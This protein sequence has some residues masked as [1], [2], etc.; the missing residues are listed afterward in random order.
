[1][2]QLGPTPVLIMSNDGAATNKDYEP[3][4]SG[5]NGQVKPF[6]FPHVPNPSSF[7]I[8]EFSPQSWMYLVME[9]P[10]LV[11]DFMMFPHEARVMEAMVETTTNATLFPMEGTEENIGAER[12]T[13]AW[14]DVTNFTLKS[15]FIAAIADRTIKAPHIKISYLPDADS[16]RV[17]WRRAMSSEPLPSEALVAGA[18]VFS[19]LNGEGDEVGRLIADGNLRSSV[20]EGARVLLIPA[21]SAMYHPRLVEISARKD[22]GIVVSDFWVPEP[23]QTEMRGS[24]LELRVT[25]DIRERMGVGDLIKAVHAGVLDARARGLVPMIAVDIDGTVLNTRK[26][27]A[28]IFRE[29]LDSYSGPDAEEIK[30]LAH[31][32]RI[33]EAWDSESIL[34]ELGVTRRETVED[35]QKY[36]YSNFHNPVRRLEMPPIQAVVELLRIFQAMG[37]GTIYNTLRNRINDE[38]PDGTSSARMIF[39]RLGIWNERSV[40][41]RD[42]VEDAE[43]FKNECNSC[44]REPLKSEKLRQYRRANPQEF[45]IATIENAPFQING[46]RKFYGDS[47]VNIH[48]AGDIPPDSPPLPEGVFTVKPD[49]LTDD[50]EGWR[51]G[52]STKGNQLADEFFLRGGALVTAKTYDFHSDDFDRAERSLRRD[53][54]SAAE[55]LQAA[56]KYGRWHPTA[57]SF[58]HLLN[59]RFAT[60]R[61]QPGLLEDILEIVN[62]YTGSRFGAARGP[63]GI[64]LIH[65]IDGGFPSDIEVLRAPATFETS[66]LQ[67]RDVVRELYLLPEALAS[68]E[69]GE[70]LASMSYSDL[71]ANLSFGKYP[72]MEAALGQLISTLSFMTGKDVGELIA[73][74]HGPRLSLAALICLAR[75]GVKTRWTE[76]SD[77]LRHQTESELLRVPESIRSKISYG[78]DVSTGRSDLAIWNL[79]S[80]GTNLREMT[81]GMEFGGIVAIQS[82]FRAD[83][84][85]EEELEH[86][87]LFDMPLHD[88]HYVLPGAVLGALSFQAWMVR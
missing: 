22:E 77:V 58:M 33:D 65:S 13:S 68:I 23:G 35:A 47:A 61:W 66:Q 15:F 3:H 55:I 34:K 8:R 19:K 21:G 40:I 60:A 4:T 12:N 70:D 76:R 20:I 24:P 84:Y 2:P 17:E 86:S 45:I 37:A 11:K 14:M 26:F 73:V 51:Y 78:D 72:R 16:Y 27:A 71:Y 38:L 56:M 30:R 54:K 80:D 75:L 74:E 64:R 57:Q 7:Q 49:Q 53:A 81:R 88:G 59:E 48:V 32:S 29:W 52:Y 1:M 83:H 39:E 41:I 5:L 82:E 43:R 10:E 50:I 46:Y 9:R 31:E 79:P 67:V 18:W 62:L 85:A 44:E 63:E 42:D 36:F 69:V 87:M 28:S 6:N 25:K